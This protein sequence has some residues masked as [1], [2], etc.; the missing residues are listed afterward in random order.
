MYDFD[1]FPLYPKE[2]EAAS[3]L[4]EQVFQASEMFRIMAKGL[5]HPLSELMD[6]KCPSNRPF[7]IILKYKEDSLCA[8]STCFYI[9][10][11]FCDEP[12]TTFVHFEEL[13]REESSAMGQGDLLTARITVGYNI[14]GNV[15]ISID[16]VYDKLSFTA[17]ISRKYEELIPYIV[18][19][20]KL[21]HKDGSS[22]DG[23]LIIMSM[24]HYLLCADNALKIFSRILDKT[25]RTYLTLLTFRT[26]WT[27][28]FGMSKYIPSRKAMTF[29][30]TRLEYHMENSIEVLE[31]INSSDFNV[32]MFSFS[33][34]AICRS[35]FNKRS[36]SPF[37][38]NIKIPKIAPTPDENINTI[39]GLISQLYEDG[40][41]DPFTPIKEYYGENKDIN[42]SICN[43]PYCFFTPEHRTSSMNK[44]L[45]AMDKVFSPSA[46]YENMLKAD[47]KFFSK[48][49]FKDFPVVLSGIGKRDDFSDYIIKSSTKHLSYMFTE[50]IKI[51]DR[52]VEKNLKSTLSFAFVDANFS[53]EKSYYI[54]HYK[55]DSSSKRVRQD[56]LVNLV[57]NYIVYLENKMLENSAKFDYS[58]SKK[59]HLAQRIRIIE[60]D[61]FDNNFGKFLD[62]LYE[63]M[64]KF[65][66]GQNVFLSANYSDALKIYFSEAYK[67]GV[68][69]IQ[70]MKY[71]YNDIS[72][73]RNAAHYSFADV[74]KALQVT[75]I[76]E[77][78]YMK[79]F[80]C[81]D[82]DFIF[83]SKYVGLK[84]KEAKR[85]MEKMVEL[86]K[87]N[88]TYSL[89]SGYISASEHKSDYMAEKLRE[90][91]N[92]LSKT[93]DVKPEIRSR[94]K[95]LLAVIISFDEF[96][97]EK[98]PE[99]SNLSKK[100]IE[101]T[102]ALHK[103]LYIKQAS[104][105]MTELD[106]EK[107]VNA[108]CN[109]LYSLSKSEDETDDNGR[110]QKLYYENDSGKSLVGWYDIKGNDY[111]ILYSGV[112]QCEIYHCFSDY[113]KKNKM[114]TCITFKQILR[115]L[116]DN[117]NAVYTRDNPSGTH[118]QSHRKI[119]GIDRKLYRIYG[120]K[121]DKITEK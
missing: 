100:L 114:K 109:Y 50:K 54:L 67:S 65:P 118:Y 81:R 5:Q 23:E 116:R 77:E 58:S 47:S 21:I 15:R 92:I 26:G 32:L 17:E 94:L 83:F 33:L 61:I 103:V 4:G 108:F 117:Y 84:K 10:S 110:Y 71:L 22:C 39:E 64:R 14:S 38:L 1:V 107:T 24:T 75:N 27:K 3:S 11:I 91:D 36:Y 9:D 112:N 87:N 119:G 51:P 73:R 68:H 80:L 89:I 86:W 98:H 44:N 40:D 106:T 101:N 35:L 56:W 12:K 55:L 7:C 102:I 82:Q 97:E 18:T 31:T 121:I 34:F 6:T 63:A 104:A 57:Y 72:Q 93:D 111:Y 52:I 74:K 70:M 120:E 2:R 95:C 8:R 90:A 25:D 42:E 66:N 105:I 59:E 20:V 16:G 69:P 78:Q 99:L 49:N 41:N 53:E 48:A 79:Y 37:L 85:E 60:E 13:I 30:R 115:S 96:V 28:V 45:F 76:T 88:Y 46:T 43:I 62:R 113:L 29:E 19:G